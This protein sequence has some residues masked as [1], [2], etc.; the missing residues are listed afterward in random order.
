MCLTCPGGYSTDFYGVDP[1]EVKTIKI[2][3]IMDKKS[4]ELIHPRLL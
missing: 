1:V 4:I 3:H 2:A